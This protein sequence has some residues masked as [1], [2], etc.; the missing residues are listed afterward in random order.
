M[1]CY[2]SLVGLLLLLFLLCG[3]QRAALAPAAS[4]GDT[5]NSG[6][7]SI[8]VIEITVPAPS[9]TTAP[10]SA[11]TALPVLTP[12]S[13]A[14][15]T[16]IPNNAALTI[17]EYE[18]SGSIKNEPLTFQPVHGTQNEVLARHADA[19]QGAYRKTTRAFLDGKQY[20]AI[21]IENRGTPETEAS[22]TD[23][24]VQVL[25]EDEVIFSTPAGDASP[26]DPIRGLW[27]LEPHWYLE[28][29]HVTTWNH[30]NT[31]HSEA[32]GQVFKDGVL[33]NERYGYDEMFGF[34]LLNGRPFYFYKVDG[35]IHLAFDH[36]DLPLVYDAIPHY[37]CCSGGATN[38]AGGP[39][40]VSLF[41]RRGD[42]WYYTEIGIY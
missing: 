6:D 36:Q 13:S 32:V 22:Y 19:R 37:R 34:Q 7:P 40:W 24:T 21:L 23:L 4:S 10:T 14:L 16:S 8:T 41:R 28:I 38:P 15:V 29:A 1:Q 30:G 31:V 18:I 5:E 9:P 42:T 39:N 17:E 11:R 20:S 26:V 2:K 33:L 25:R 27:V 35:Q 12:T 3:C